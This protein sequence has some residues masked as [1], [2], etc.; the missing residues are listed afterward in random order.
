MI[1]RD[2]LRKLKEEGSRERSNVLFLR[3]GNYFGKL[4][5]DAGGNLLS[6][7]AFY[8]KV[9]VVG[10][11]GNLSTRYVRDYNGNP[12]AEVLATLS[13]MGVLGGQA[14]KWEK[15][16]LAK[17]LFYL[18][19]AKVD[20]EIKSGVYVLAFFSAFQVRSVKA[21]L[22]TIFTFDEG[23]EEEALRELLPYFDPNV[24]NKGVTI[25]FVG[26][27]KGNLTM[28]TT[29]GVKI[30]PVQMPDWA[31]GANLDHLWLDTS[32]DWSPDSSYKE[33]AKSA[34]EEFYHLAVSGRLN[35]AAAERVAQ[36]R[37]HEF[38]LQPQPPAP[39]I[40]QVSHQQS[41]GTNIQQPG[42]TSRKT[43][44][45]TQVNYVP[46]QRLHPMSEEA[47]GL[48]TL[49]L[50]QDGVPLCFGNYDSSSPKC[51]RCPQMRD[52]LLSA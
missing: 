43:L 20:R 46:E 5:P 26:G 2:F 38:P 35:P 25:S 32:P 29:S 40:P 23:I 27:K 21:A 8:Y 49:V 31:V 48:N 34:A 36:Q 47:G 14:W 18:H 39:T 45:I 11:D 37:Q 41:G 12:V 51:I 13:S 7:V 16:P 9:P 52:C 33:M 6:N 15:K 17:A 22:S 3:E 24:P 42:G 10:E 4:L 44:N 19:A 50:D 30:P 1:N 28:T